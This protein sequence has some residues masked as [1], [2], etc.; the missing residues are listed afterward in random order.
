[1]KLKRGEAHV[2]TQHGIE[3][4][5]GWGSLMGQASLLYCIVTRGMLTSVP[6]TIQICQYFTDFLLEILK[7]FKKY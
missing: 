7:D 6:P 5:R 2:H 4:A 3:H 1:M